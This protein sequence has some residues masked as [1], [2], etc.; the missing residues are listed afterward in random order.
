MFEHSEY[1]QNSKSESR[2]HRES[3]GDVRYSQ[4]TVDLEMRQKLEVGHVQEES[5]AQHSSLVVG[6]SS[7]R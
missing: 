5:M 2:M 6:S 4:K 7:N 1:R 3:T